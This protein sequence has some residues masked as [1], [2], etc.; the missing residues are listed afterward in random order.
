MAAAGRRSGLLK[1]N[2]SRHLWVVVVVVVVVIVAVMVMMARA[3][4]FFV[5]TPFPSPS[6]AFGEYL[7]LF[8]VSGL[9]SRGIDERR[10]TRLGLSGRQVGLTQCVEVREL[11]RLPSQLIGDA[12]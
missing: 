3:P 10:E 4:I 5:Y 2:P 12:S 9:R 1:R 11:W 8:D 6:R 7:L